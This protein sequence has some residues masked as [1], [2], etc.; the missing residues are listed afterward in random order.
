MAQKVRGEQILQEINNYY[1]FPIRN[2]SSQ[3]VHLDQRF[4]VTFKWLAADKNPL[5]KHILK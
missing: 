3:K 4:N 2:K 5:Y 1:I